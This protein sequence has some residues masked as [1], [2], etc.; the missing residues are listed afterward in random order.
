V[1]VLLSAAAIALAPPAALLIRSWRARVAVAG[2]SMEPTL[3]HGDWLLVDPNAYVDEPPN[4][5]ELVVAAD[6]RQA[7]RL[8][9]KRVAAVDSGGRL[10]LCGDHPAHAVEA[11]LWAI[12]GSAVAG[13]PWLRCWPLGRAGL[14]R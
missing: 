1:A 4:P 11:Q 12:P 14:L 6:P 7:G 8:I 2:H 13:R 10:R 3:R 9:V 5:G